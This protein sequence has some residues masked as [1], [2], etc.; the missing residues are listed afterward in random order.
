MIFWYNFSILDS[1]KSTKIGNFTVDQLKEMRKNDFLWYINEC[2]GEK[3]EKNLNLNQ[4]ANLGFNFAQESQTTNNSIQSNSFEGIWSTNL[5]GGN[6]SQQPQEPPQQELQNFSFSPNNNIGQSSFGSTN[7]QAQQQ[8]PQQPGFL[9]YGMFTPGYTEQNNQQQQQ[10]ITGVFGI[11]QGNNN[12]NNNFNFSQ[13]QPQQQQQQLQTHRKCQY[14]KKFE[15]EENISQNDQL[16][17]TLKPEVLLGPIPAAGTQ[18]FK[19]YQMV[20]PEQLNMMDLNRLLRLDILSY[21]N[22]ALENFLMQKYY[23]YTK[24]T[25]DLEAF[26]QPEEIEKLIVRCKIESGE[27]GRAHV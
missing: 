26:Y 21:I 9:S 5:F 18:E 12:T 19:Y 27:I 17:F 3:I 24:Q 13:M 8:Q 14:A 2:K 7:N 10:P 6:I 23:E 4:G 15:I 1:T 25:T 20:T 16:F 11:I 22:S